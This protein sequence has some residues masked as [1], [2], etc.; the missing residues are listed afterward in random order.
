LNEAELNRWAVGF[1][2][3]GCRLVTKPEEADLL[4]LNTCAVTDAGVRKSRQ[5]MG[6]MQRANPNA[7]LV[8]SG[9]HASL[10]PEEARR[11]LGVDL[12]VTNQEKDDLVAIVLDRLQPRV[13]PTQAYETDPAALFQRG[14]HRAF[15]KV[16]DGCRYRCSY[17]IVTVARG[18]ERSRPLPAI[19]DEVHGLASQGVREIVLTGVQLGGYGAGIGASLPA[20][21]TTLLAETDVPRIRLGSVEPWAAA[22]QGDRLLRLFA[23]PRLMPHIHLPLQSG[24]DAVLRRMARPTRFADFRAL[25]GE[26]RAAAGQMN[27]TTDIIAGFPGETEADW[28]ASM[29]EVQRLGL[30]H[31]H[32][33][34]YSDRPGTK[35]ARLPDKVAPA[36]KKA[37]VRE[38]LAVAAALHRRTLQRAVGGEVP[39]L[40]EGDE[41]SPFPPGARVVGYTP[42]Y[43][44]VAAYP[45]EG[46]PLANTIHPARLL[47]VSDD[48][49][50]AEARLLPL[51]DRPTPSLDAGRP[52]GAESPGL[53]RAS[54]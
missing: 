34:P 53:T 38:M 35:A 41:G 14:R 1:R 43:L 12:V 7:K 27:V 20:L 26:L 11:S 22:G 28:Q 18:A 19:V 33:F 9:C 37:R 10:A 6:R 54:R 31:I 30:G 3:A 47:R 5:L 4:V 51:L 23:N 45:R 15:V 49:I 25:V 13:G 50:H 42:N 2:A 46:H 48:G 52:F 8:V 16:Q 17:C 40:W 24:S 29:E 44:R 21:V 32:V 39:V 36:I